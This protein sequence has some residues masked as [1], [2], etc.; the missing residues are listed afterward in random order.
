M[1]HFVYHRETRLADTDGGLLR[2]RTV[3]L[4]PCSTCCR[5]LLTLGYR[6]FSSFIFS[7]H[8][9]RISFV[10]LRTDHVRRS[11]SCFPVS[12]LTGLFELL[13]RSGCNSLTSP[14]SRTVI[15]S[16]VSVCAEGVCDLSNSSYSNPCLQGYWPIL[17]N[18]NLGR[19]WFVNVS[20]VCLLLC[21]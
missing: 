17:E 21:G 19:Q 2:G 7:Y 15:S 3:W 10:Q 16:S 11:Q 8:A 5:R 9:A 1:R 18:R 14:I 4:S 20:R 12:I 6:E 13:R